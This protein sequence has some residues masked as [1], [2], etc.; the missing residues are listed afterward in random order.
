MELDTGPYPREGGM[1]LS[2]GITIA[3]RA[4]ITILTRG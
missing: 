4:V 2:D 3:T 1:E